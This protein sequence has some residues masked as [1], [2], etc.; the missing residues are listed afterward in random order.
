MRPRL[1]TGCLLGLFMFACAGFFPRA[2]SAAEQSCD[3][4]CL[5]GFVDQ[6]LAA[7]V[8]RDPAKLPL[9][10]SVKFTEDGV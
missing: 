9:A 4:A 2:A 10:K 7:M 8:A 3:R 5:T 6:Y 1:L